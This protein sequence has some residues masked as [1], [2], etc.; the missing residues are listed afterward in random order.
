MK[1]LPTPPRPAGLAVALVV[2]LAAGLV[3]TDTLTSEK[4]WNQRETG[5]AATGTPRLV[6]FDSCEA[7][8]AELRE[9]MRPFVG[10]YGLPGDQPYGVAAD[11]GFA[12]GVD[13]RAAVPNAAPAAGE[14][15][16]SA[17][18]KRQ[19][20]GTNNHER[21]VEEPD[22]VQTDGNRVVSVVDGT[23]RV[24]DVGSTAVTAEV[25][26]PGGPATELLLHGD[27]ALVL[28]AGGVAAAPVDPGFA[29]E[30]G[31]LRS[32]LVLV[33]LAGPAEVV[34]TLELDG[35]YVDA[36]AIEGRA[37]IVVRSAPR[38]PFTHPHEAGSRES[39]LRENREILER[40]SIEDW[41]P[42]YELTGNGTRQEG[43]LV[44]CARVSHPDTYSGTAMLTVLTVE[45]SGRLGTGDPVSI[46]AEGD[47][48]Y[49]T[50]SS[51][52][53]ADDGY[54]TAV[55][56]P[57]GRMPMPEWEP[58]ARR[59]EIHQ[60]DIGR[61]GP[62]RHV[63]SGTVEGTLLN[64]YSLSEYEGHLRVA[65]TTGAAGVP[66][67]P[68]EVPNSVSAVTVLAR[69]DSELAQVGRV[70][71]LGKGER[72][73]A[74]RFVG[75][76]GYVVT[77]RE[78]DPLY[79]VDL[80]DPAAPRVVGELKITGYSAY[81]HDAGAGR[82]IGVGQEANRQG[83]TSGLQVSLFDVGDPAA[84]SRIAQQ[85]V[86]GARSEVESDPHAFLYWPP[87]GLIVLPY[88]SPPTGPDWEHGGGALV[89]RL[90]ER[91][92][93]EVG[94][95]RQ[96]AESGSAGDGV[97]RRAMVIGD[98][99]WTVSSAGAL[100]SEVGDGGTNRVAWIPFS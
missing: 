28:A 75:P 12:E 66:R 51:L 40:S 53:V 42:R 35:E 98:R 16:G 89:L 70:G 50:E 74:V 23:L 62:P 37:R 55:P 17:G 82:L 20:S 80:A 86:A 36:R 18:K 26:L 83:R 59:T 97:V 81:L 58:E 6:S 79:T 99:L 88:T 41:L 65:T 45:L 78:T 73:Y 30:P 76:V 47:T 29:P 1:R 34:G 39:A 68:D 25:D 67:G 24:V 93:T 13:G 87:S 72:I 14:D 96:P 8:L 15:A 19:H 69:K 3:V 22:L 61:P 27:R 10:P 46:V 85:H 64:Q 94:T 54:P 11:S 48:V 33:D 90:G 31:G 63:A 21:G 5:T 60:F 91:G 32:R 2:V 100:V 52:Y 7:A 56:M 43:N 57:G 9:S 95:V 84:P 71:G 49:G 4:P 77:F 92:M 38:L 44:D